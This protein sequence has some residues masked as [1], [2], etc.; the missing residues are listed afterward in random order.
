[1]F[2]IKFAQSYWNFAQ[3]KKIKNNRGVKIWSLELKKPKFGATM[4]F[5]EDL[6]NT[7]LSN[8]KLSNEASYVSV[9]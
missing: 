4:L 6:E 2:N 3:L 7:P 5:P 8:K 1:M 9:L